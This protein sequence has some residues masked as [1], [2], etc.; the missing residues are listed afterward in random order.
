MRHQEQKGEWGEDADDNNDREIVKG[1][2]WVVAHTCATTTSIAPW[3]GHMWAQTTTTTAA[4][5][6]QPCVRNGKTQTM[7]TT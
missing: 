6:W 5:G 4:A 2:V 7:T 3:W 1:L